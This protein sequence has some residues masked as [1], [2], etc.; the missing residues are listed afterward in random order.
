MQVILQQWLPLETIPDGV[1]THLPQTGF[2]RR[3]FAI[4]WRASLVEITVLILR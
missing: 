3:P 4:Y 1:L 2:L